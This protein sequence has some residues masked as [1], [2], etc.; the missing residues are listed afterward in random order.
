MALLTIEY[1][2]PDF[3]GWKQIFDKDPMG[4]SSHGVT[5]HWIYQDADNP[6]HVMLSMEFG[7]ADDARR[8]LNEPAFQQVWDRSGARRAWVLEEAEAATY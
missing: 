2:V 6:N 8:F 1:Q 4:R 3:A 5:R 7:S